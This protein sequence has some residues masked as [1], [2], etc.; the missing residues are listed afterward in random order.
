MKSNKF[1]YIII[2]V[3][4]IIMFNILY[5]L[6]IENYTTAII[7]NIA[8]VNV[9]LLC[10]LGCFACMGKGK[11]N[12]FLSYTKLSFAVVYLVF[13]TVISNLLILFNM[14]NWKVAVGFQVI[15]FIVFAILVLS[16][17]MVDNAS[18]ADTKAVREKVDHLKKYSDRLYQ[19]MKLVEDNVT[20]YKTLEKAYDGI[21]SAKMNV[22]DTEQIDEDIL[23]QIVEIEKC[24]N[25]GNL[26]EISVKADNINKLILKRNNA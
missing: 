15:A 16:N 23:V 14:Q 17:K 26:D 20:V 8:G 25:D 21:R 1:L 12:P 13:V 3:L 6:F 22:E 4:A 11:E 24:I 5:V 19:A 2:C 10:T 18:E 7:V 9:A